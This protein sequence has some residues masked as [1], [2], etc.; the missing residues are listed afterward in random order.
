[1]TS[2]GY[3]GT[4]ASGLIET[5]DQVMVLPSRKLSNVR[6]IVTYDGELSQAYPPQAIT[7]TLEDE[8]DISRG[9]MLVHP[10][11]LPYFSERIDAQ[12]V[13]MAE[14]PLQP[15]KQ[16]LFK[17]ACRKSTGVV[18]N[19]RFSIDVNSLERAEAEVLQL[20]E[21]GRC[22]IRLS[23][24]IAFDSY[25]A[26]RATGAFIIIDRLTN[27]TVG[28][29]MIV[30]TVNA[31]TEVTW[32]ASPPHADL[33]Y[34]SSLI[35][36]AERFTQTGQTPK[37]LLLTGL[38]GSGKSTLA[39]ALERKLFDMGRVAIVLDGQNMR[40]GPSKDLGFDKDA[41]A[42]NL[43]R[44]IE[45]AQMMNEAGLIA[46]CAFVA[47]DAEVRRKARERVGESFILAYLNCPLEVCKARDQDGFYAAAEEGIDTVPGG[48]PAL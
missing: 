46:I 24:R 47:P 1:M 16:Y 27:V 41:R 30:G 21:I 13:W 29:G 36:T 25:K 20:N 6:S 19:I 11:N 22:E 5:G 43:R 26:N 28:A 18:S 3:S 8:I 9:D 33:K 23:R 45:I 7:I 12:V 44:S 48:E 17:Q 31:K 40:L 15:N 4:V 10:N 2:G 32:E 37:I 34:S 14:A 39:Y 42:E 38:T 35:S